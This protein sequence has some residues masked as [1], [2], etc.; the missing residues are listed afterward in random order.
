MFPVGLAPIS[1]HN[2]QTQRTEWEGT[3]K[4]SGICSGLRL[5]PCEQ[6]T[7]A[8]RREP[9]RGEQCSNCPHRLWNP[10]SSLLQEPCGAEDPSPMKWG[11]CGPDCQELCLGLSQL[12]FGSRVAL[13]ED[14][15]EGGEKPVKLGLSHWY[16]AHEA[17]SGCLCLSPDLWLFQSSLLSH[18]SLFPHP[19]RSGGSQAIALGFLYIDCTQVSLNPTSDYPYL[20]VSSFSF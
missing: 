2:P 3:Y 10:P 20:R 13:V 18:E 8:G 5:V 11:C 17:P 19:F 6:A 12:D 4:A 15:R 16:P 14:G 1:N 7:A 9:E